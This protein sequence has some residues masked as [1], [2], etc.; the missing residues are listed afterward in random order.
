MKEVEPDGHGEVT[1]GHELNLHELS[2]VDIQRLSPNSYP[3]RVSHG[4]LKT[5]G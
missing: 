1:R 5:C 2:S 4:G 3:N